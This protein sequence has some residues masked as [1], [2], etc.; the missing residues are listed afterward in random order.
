M[1]H[2]RRIKVLLATCLL[3]CSSLWAQDVKISLA[4]ATAEATSDQGGD[5]G[6]SSAIDG[7]YSKFWHSQWSWGA[8]FE[9]VSSVDL[10]IAL[11]EVTLVDYVR[12]I[13]RQ[14]SNQGH[15]GE[16]E[17]FYSPNTT[18]TSF[19]SVG[20]F[21]LNMADIPHDFFLNGT[22]GV[23]CG[24]IN[25][26]IRS[27]SNNHATAAEI[28]MYQL[29]KD[30][31]NAFAQC[32]S[33]AVYT[34]LKPGITSSS[35]ADAD[36]RALV[37]SMQSNS[38]SY[39]KFRVGKYEAYET[40]GTLQQRLKT[41]NQYSRY[42]NPTG[43]YFTAGQ[44]Y[45]VA[46]SGIEDDAVGLKVKNWY[47]S[48]SS[49][50]YSL[51]NGLN[52]IKATTEGNVFVN[53]YTDNY[54]EAPKVKVHFINAPVIGYWDQET[55]TNSDWEEMLKDKAADD[56]R[57]IITQSEHAQ[58]AFPISA[59][60][61]H[62]PDDV[63][64]LMGHYQ[65][66]Q[67]ALRDMMG[68][69]KYGYQTRNRQIFYV[70]DGG[71]MAAGGEGAYCD[72]AD[73]GGIMN[74]NSFDFWGVAHEWGHNN[75]IDPGFHWSGCG[76]TTNNIYA[77]WAQYH[78]T[79][80]R[81][82][83]GN[84][85]F[86]RLEDEVSGIDEYSDMRGGRM[87]TYFE[88][89]VRKGVAWQLQD[90]PDYHNATPNTITVTGRDADGNDIGEVTTTSRNYDHFVKLTP[91]WQLNLWGNKA[92][93]CPDIITDVIHSIRTA[94][95]YAETYNTNGKQQIN[96]M[97]L[98]CDHAGIDLLPFFEKAGMLRPIHA[99]I[100]DYGAGW[101]IITEGMINE[102][103]AYVAQKGYPAYTEEINYINA[104]NMHIY[105]D[106]LKLNVT[107]MQGERNGDKV[108]IQHSIAQNA[109]AFE[110]YNAQDE[111]IR[112]TMYGLGSNDEHSFTQ[113][114]FPSDAA[115][116]MAV[117][118]DGMR[119][120][121]Y[122]ELFD[123]S[124]LQALIVQTKA[125]VNVMADVNY[126]SDIDMKSCNITSN[127]AS[128]Y[129]TA[130]LVDGDPSTFFHSTYI[131]NTS[132]KHNLV[133]DLGSQ[134]S[135][136]EFMI[137]YTTLPG[138]FNTGTSTN[139]TDAPT[140]ISVEGSNDGSSYT[141]IATL[142]S[143][144]PTEAG[145]EYTSAVLGDASIFYRYI[146]LTV[147]ATNGGGMAGYG[148]YYFGLAELSLSCPI[149]VNA[150]GDK[151]ADFI[152]VEQIKTACEQILIAQQKCTTG[153]VTS[154]D[155]A[156]LQSQYDLLLDIYNRGD[157]DAFNALKEELLTLIDDAT[158]LISTCGTITYIPATL[159]G[160][161][162]LQTNNPNGSW[163][164][165]SNADQNAGGN[166]NDGG[167]IAALVDNNYN[168][169]FHTRWDGT[170]VNEPHH[171]QVDM[172][173]G[174]AINDFVFSYK[175][176]NN[177]PAPTSMI[178]YGSNDENSFTEVLAT[179]ESGL[180]AH[181]S[182]N[183]YTSSTIVSDKA[184]RYLR[185]IVTGSQ[186]P[187]NNKYNNQY[188][189]GMLEFDL[190]AVGRPESYTA[191]L[192]A[193][194]GEVTSDLLL[195]TFHAANDAQ[196]VYDEAITESQL[197]NAIIELQAKYDALHSAM[198]PNV[199]YT[200]SVVGGSNGGV[201]YEGQNYTESLSA[202]A[203]LSIGELSAIVLDGYVAKVTLEGQTI[204]I[205]YNKV[206]TVTIIGGEGEGRLTFNET[207]YANDETF[208]ALQSS[209]TAEAFS[210]KDVEGYNKSEV[211]VNHETGIISVT[212]T[213]DKT[214]L[215]DLLE[216]TLELIAYCNQTYVNSEF[217]TESLISET[218]TARVTAQEAL[219][220][221]TTRSEFNA[222]VNALQEAHD[223]LDEAKTLAEDEAT[224]RT[225]LNRLLSALITET[226]TLITSCYENDVLKFVNSE[227]VTEETISAVRALVE[228]AEAKCSTPGT[229]ATE[230]NASIS[231]LTEAKS[232][233]T[234]AIENAEE[235]AE[236]RVHLKA[237]LQ[238]LVDNTNTLMA[239]CGE[240][241][242]APVTTLSGVVT[243]QT[244]LSAEDFY[245]S[246]NAQEESE[247]DIAGL[248]DDDASTFFHSS[249]M[250]RVN[251]AHYLQVDM[252][253]QYA[254]KE[255]AFGYVTR[256]NGRGGPHPSTI[257]VSG[258]NS[259]DNDSFVELRVI[260]SGL[261]TGGNE[262]WSTTENIV[263]PKMP[264]RYLR[265]TVTQSAGTN[266]CKHSNP[267][268]YFFTMSKFS[269]TAVPTEATPYADLN[270]NVGAVTEAQLLEVYYEKKSAL[271]IINSANNTELTVAKEALQA[272]YD[273]LNEAYAALDKSALEALLP[274]VEMLYNACY[275]DGALNYTG[276]LY[277]TAELMT[278]VEGVI[279]AAYTALDNTVSQ[280]VYEAALANLKTAQAKLQ[281]AIN[282]AALPVLLTTTVEE[283]VL[284]I[285][286]S[287][288]GDTKVLQYYPADEHTFG[289]AEKEKGSAK[290]LFFF[291]EGDAATQ[292]YVYPFVAGEQ[293]LSADNTDQGAKKVFAKA[294]DEMN[295]Q[296][297]TFHKLTKDGV[298]CYGL[299][300]VGTSTYFSNFG[301]GSAKMGFYNTL[302][303]GGS[304]FTFTK[305]TIE[306]SAAYH[307]LKVYYDE[308]TK[309]K[310]AEIEGGSNP[311]YYP[312]QEADAY[313][314]AYANTTDL[315]G[316]MTLAYVD[317]LEAYK[318]LKAANEVLE[319]N[320]PEEGKYY[321][322]VSACEGDRGGQLMYATGEN[323][324]KFS[325]EK[326]A[327]SPDALWTFTEEGY[328]MNLQTGCAINV[329]CSWGEKFKL[330]EDDHKVVSIESLSLDGQVKLTPANGLPLHAQTTGSV[331][332]GWT[333][334]ANDASAWRIVEVEDM[335]LVNFALSMSQ[336]E[337]A[338]LY[339]NYAVEIPENVDAYYIAGNDIAIDAE[340]VG[341]LKLTKIED[342]VIPA[343]TGV[344]LNAPAGN[345]AFNYVK[346]DATIKGNLLT[347]CT[348]LQYR[349]AEEGH[350]YYNFGQKEGVVG[351]YKNSV[352]YD[353]AG[354]EG[355]THYKMSAN[356]VLF[357]W[358]NTESHVTS[359]RFS[360][361]EETGIEG[362]TIDAD[363][364]IY[365]LY[366]R[367]VLEVVTPGLYIIN[368]EKRYIQVK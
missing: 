212:Y 207:E 113:V 124:E 234:T 225:E 249:W 219:E 259:T 14:G 253:E 300:P 285:M 27:G 295:K 263:T 362:I 10:T 185:F 162:A 324:M 193:Q 32:F 308:V 62:C 97:K 95:N 83:E 307:S 206:Y 142:S 24:Q 196:E 255:F 65:N 198:Y 106:K 188:F 126:G 243:L 47:L 343:R 175:P 13:P 118:Y 178:V 204:T 292:V 30:K 272:K 266:G 116:I 248:T 8:V 344:I 247:G 45:L 60:K 61:T 39:K 93:K 23:N 53:Y 190:T 20:T 9:K 146:R 2:L 159:D 341:T 189:F 31:L 215:N 203:T 75:Q 81:D 158:S 235:E 283:P 4:K 33:D 26:T 136:S 42:E 73:L 71:F 145:K 44:S 85:T 241:R 226:K 354:A 64:A 63:E 37:Q 314:E 233:L 322:I 238:T 221:V 330:G 239:L 197:Q 56:N 181:N 172:G 82:A 331:I 355:T 237:E 36:V 25:F 290:Q 72:Y 103:K 40:L 209:F 160:A 311:Y 51:R 174:V 150:I 138:T 313:N 296:Q 151:Y 5:E 232:N 84:P 171:I 50:T 240:I 297:W 270:E 133:I 107:T 323:G 105:R 192:G 291:M 167:G 68:L 152:S 153:T 48:E 59:W 184:Y 229:T 368:G 186:G 114:L 202:P 265:F 252:G 287:K 277:V 361:G 176:R 244:T 28:E 165:S 88:E 127:Y 222:A 74:A 231:E 148:K 250:A 302:D 312:K 132:A 211:T 245:L 129:G 92:G 286:N 205:I 359:F 352:K 316:T 328:M 35:I 345:Y 299:Q 52:Y 335:S 7:D 183:T 223:K 363:A 349:A 166:S 333:S 19:T 180:P 89:A 275:I 298:D 141:D 218:N 319:L 357:D 177:S 199:E 288:R 351:L 43:V 216:E 309:V 117:G 293:V 130:N 340:G 310:S 214:A 12:Y 144:L 366:G 258:S 38:T 1:Y 279:S 98:A 200:I 41:K 3:A 353:A 156:A 329:V 336:Y 274:E 327:Q 201:Q 86:L 224:E 123:E 90:G 22:E 169:Y 87:Q 101:N 236:Q 282:H 96:W 364:T 273:A 58:T 350:S 303:D 320:M 251:E 334:N 317:Y 264:Y 119:Q 140:N 16:V 346:S 77:S 182:G 267:D 228:A 356:K 195:A 278:E 69:E 66:V 276:S 154:E 262:S 112:I 164:V 115:Y 179:I 256:N 29:D 99:Y 280:E 46:V 213:L 301:G 284:Y 76:E 227:F 321:T 128:V 210:I 268:E 67:W 155:I 120:I 325:G 122:S 121:V 55:M 187:G 94:E 111:L 21:N 306:G 347:G 305:T 54:A 104:H 318:A 254:L 91:F 269:L 134:Q 217:V 365:D 194:A 139:A 261:P 289:I 143:G 173:N 100:E 170:T 257:V 102:L 338:G 271:S 125:L 17:V 367:R 348:Y 70:V 49:S 304:L 358:D 315:L 57:I 168:T 326:T 80:N 339:L 18:G 131:G 294:K 163:Y 15:W 246:T 332:V 147:N 157:N 337:H 79:A 108:I 110:T 281:Y 135:V 360:I 260:N 220:T 6:A 137:N 191:E 109:V 34:E 149:T 342:G 161:L 208:N 11:S 242:T 230:F 78:F